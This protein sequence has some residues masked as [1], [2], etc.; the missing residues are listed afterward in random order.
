MI[1]RDKKTFW[2]TTNQCDGQIQICK[3][4]NTY[5]GSYLRCFSGTYML[6]ENKSVLMVDI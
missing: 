5:Y 4:Q 3:P 6:P 2:K 1:G